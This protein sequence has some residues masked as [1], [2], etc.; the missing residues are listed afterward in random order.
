MVNKFRFMVRTKNGLKSS[1]TEPYQYILTLS[2]TGKLCLFE[3][4]R[5]EAFLSDLVFVANFFVHC[6]FHNGTGQGN[7][8]LK[9]LNCT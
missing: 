5:Y 1:P 9:I 3:D 8:L 2:D 7:I 4:K 6:M